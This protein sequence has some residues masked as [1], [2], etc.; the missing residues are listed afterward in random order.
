MVLE[1]KKDDTFPESQLFIEG[2]S[3]PYRLDQTAKR[4][5]IFFYIRQDIS[6]KCLKKTTVSKSF[7]GFFVELNL[8]SKKWLLGCS[9]NPHK[10]KNNFLS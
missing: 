6:T 8:R 2:F 5:G 1:T 3:T 7:E 10:E 9:Y 4:K